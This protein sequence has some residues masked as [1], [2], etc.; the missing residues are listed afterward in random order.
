VAKSAYEGELMTANKGADYLVWLAQLLV[1]WR[2]RSDPSEM[3]RN[4]DHSEFSHEEIPLLYQ[5]NMG[6]V[7]VIEGAQGN[8]RN[9]KHIKVRYYFVRELVKAG[10]LVV[11]WVSTLKMVADILTKG[12]TWPVFERLLPK[13]IGKR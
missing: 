7:Q 1:G 13:L 5:D 3:Y 10:E 9:S 6:A 2:V 11:V 8:F 12:V 4:E